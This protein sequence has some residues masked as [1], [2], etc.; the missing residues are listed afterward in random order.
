M[1]ANNRP[2][3]KFSLSD[4]F[5]LLKKAKESQKTKL[6]FYISYGMWK[7]GSTYAFE[8]T[9]AM[10]MKNGYLQPRLSDRA[11]ESGH[12]INFVCDWTATQLNAIL[13]EVEKHNT[14]IVIKTHRSPSSEVIKLLD[15]DL[16]VGHAVYR[17]PRD[18]ALSLLDAGKMARE[19]GYKAFS[20]IHNL[21]DAVKRIKK[22]IKI[23][24]QWVDLNNIRPIAYHDFT[25]KPLKLASLVS[26]QTD[27]IPYQIEDAEKIKQSRFI[28]FNKG[29]QNRYQTEMSKSEQEKI[30]KYFQVFYE[31]F[32]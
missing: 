11:V 29:K 16:A 19:K 15:S 18:I 17:D 27:L 7:S 6:K 25:Q 24:Q 8:L 4:I 5:P 28:Q 32:I 20:D 1:F 3:S 2:K 23:F 21:D 10:F 31:S 14:I 22:Q 9:K 26:E 13:N 30:R 12:N